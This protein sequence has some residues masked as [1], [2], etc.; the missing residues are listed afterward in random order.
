MALYVTEYC[1]NGR[2]IKRIKKLKPYYT[3]G[4]SIMAEKKRF[5]LLNRF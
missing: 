1:G 3:V 2:K 5:E 4:F